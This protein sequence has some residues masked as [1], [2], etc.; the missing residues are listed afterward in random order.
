MADAKDG[1]AGA[2]SSKEHVENVGT[3]A[4]SSSGH[5]GGAGGA[6]AEPNA[7]RGPTDRSYLEKEQALVESHYSGCNAADEWWHAAA[8]AF[9]GCPALAIQDHAEVTASAAGIPPLPR[10]HFRGPGGKQYSTSYYPGMPIGEVYQLAVA[11]LLPAEILMRL[12]FRIGAMALHP[13]QHLSDAAAGDEYNT[14]VYVAAR[15]GKPV[16]RVNRGPTAMARAAFGDCSLLQ[17][18]LCSKR[19]RSPQRPQ[20]LH[21]GGTIH[22]A[23]CDCAACSLL[24]G[25]PGRC[26]WKEDEGGAATQPGVEDAG[27]DATTP[28]SEP[29]AGEAEA[30]AGAADTSAGAKLGTC[31]R[32]SGIQDAS[33]AILQPS[34]PAPAST[35]AASSAGLGPANGAIGQATN[36]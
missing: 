21:Y 29:R 35:G 36:A 34:A 15:G 31:R 25:F 18:L 9:K 5:A 26:S 32:E 12:R 14:V 4:S 8:T 13:S 2:S 6:A 3:G 19:E 1:E 23:V 17:R 28:P 22:A 10:M 7:D 11:R 33:D 27:G 16:G 30:D 24:H 20:M